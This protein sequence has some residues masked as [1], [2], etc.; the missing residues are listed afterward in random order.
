MT[1]DIVVQGR[2]LC[3]SDVEWIRALIAAH[4]DWHRTQLSREICRY[5]E[6]KDQIGRY[7]DMACRTLLLK[8]ERRGL[9]QLPQR[10]GPS[11]NHRRGRAFD[12]VLH[13]TRPIQGGLSDLTPISLR[14]ADQGPERALWQ[15]LLHAYHYL[16]FTTRVGKSI[17][18]LAF[19]RQ[20]RP[21]A[22]LLF[23]AAAWKVDGRDRFIGWSAS[24]RRRN[25]QCLA[26]NMRF[27]IPPWVR[28]PHLASHVLALVARR[29]SGDWKQKYGH[30]IELLETFVEK[31]RFAGTCYRAANWVTV[32]ETTG[33]TR[34]DVYRSIS[35]PIKIVMVY[36]LRPDFRRQLREE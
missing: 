26:N 36:P 33:R 17:S 13:D 1:E 6:W 18:Y 8:L 34:N 30:R 7:K 16:G 27:L 22:A 10:R 12:L 25:L 35:S 11:V 24:Q 3:P 9:L 31:P 32:G 4:P 28:V 15:T 14:F 5:W 21:V 23:G 20:Q 29:I 19:D 2:R